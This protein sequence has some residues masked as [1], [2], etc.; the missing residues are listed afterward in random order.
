MRRNSHAIDKNAHGCQKPTK[1]SVPCTREFA[2][3]GAYICIIIMKV[4]PR[5]LV[6]EFEGPAASGGHRNLPRHIPDFEREKRV[7]LRPHFPTLGYFQRTRNVDVR[8]RIQA[9]SEIMIPSGD[10][11]NTSASTAGHENNFPTG[12]RPAP[13]AG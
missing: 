7:Y 3:T 8:I 12:E 1:L 10:F 13:M 2:V 11:S 9:Y 4:V 6:H 5:R